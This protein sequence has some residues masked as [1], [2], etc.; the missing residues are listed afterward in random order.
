M[1]RIRGYFVVNSRAQK[2][3]IHQGVEEGE[4]HIHLPGPSY[5]PL[6]LSAAIL[7]AVAGLL[8]ISWLR[9]ACAR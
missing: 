1:L 2:H 3:E 8:F 4:H 7:V 5:W 6:L 9:N